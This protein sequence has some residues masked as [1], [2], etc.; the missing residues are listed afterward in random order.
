MKSHTVRA[1]F[2]R[3]AKLVYFITDGIF[4]DGADKRQFGFM[5]FTE[6]FK[7]NLGE[8]SCGKIKFAKGLH[9]YD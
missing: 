6:D 2:D 4:C 1:V 9:L 3:G 7:V 8:E 5:R